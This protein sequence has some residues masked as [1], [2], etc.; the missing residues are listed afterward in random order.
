MKGP[1]RAG[2]AA[3]AIRDAVP[4]YQQFSTEQYTVPR[5]A[6]AYERSWYF[7][8]SK[9]ENRRAELHAA[10]DEATTLFQHVD[11]YLLAHANHYID[12]VRTLSPEQRARIRLVYDTGGSSARQGH[13]WVQLGVG[14]FIGHPGGNIAPAFYVW[15]LPRW[16]KDQDAEQAMKAA[17]D[18]VR[19]LL[20]GPAGSVMKVFLDRDALWLGT[21]AQLFKRPGGSAEPRS[22]ARPTD[23]SDLAPPGSSE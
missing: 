23:S 2:E 17:N 12:E 15:F 22:G 21:E 6:A 4:G 3:I 1:H 10:L 8:E 14:T 11:L 7:T 16:V 13:E 18:E 19:G 5:L 9:T 20:Y